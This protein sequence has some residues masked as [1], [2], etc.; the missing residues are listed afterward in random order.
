MLT[1]SYYLDAGWD[2]SD[3]D[4]NPADWQMVRPGEDYPR[5]AWQQPIAGD[6]A[7]LWGVDMIDLEDFLTNWLQEDPT[8]TD[9]TDFAEIAVNWLVN[10]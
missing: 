1:Q 6:T 10:N 8:G 9:L 3:T 2:F 4:G 7:G 5:L